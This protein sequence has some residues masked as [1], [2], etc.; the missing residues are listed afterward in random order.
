MKI[1]MHAYKPVPRDAWL[2]HSQFVIVEAGDEAATAQQLLAEGHT[3]I[4]THDETGK[5]GK[6]DRSDAAESERE[7]TE[8]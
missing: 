7:A 8:D 5:T 2:N 3:L 1:H 4:L 6:W